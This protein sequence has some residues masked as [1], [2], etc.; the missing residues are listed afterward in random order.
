MEPLSTIGTAL[1]LLSSLSSQTFQPS[2]PASS[3]VSVAVPRS[4]TVSMT[5]TPQPFNLA[6]Q[7][8]KHRVL[9]VFAPS[10]Q[11]PAYQQQ[12]RL[13]QGQDA[14]VHDRDLLPIEVL[15]TGTSRANGTAIATDSA[16]ALRQQF[17]I[18]PTEFAVILVGKDGT[19]KQRHSTPVEPATIF[20]TIDA[21]PMRQQEIRRKQVSPAE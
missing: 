3:P 11:S 15:A 17:G 5:Q 18:A 6:A 4:S 1:L 9:L 13:W 14:E 10:E 16:N 21:M 19:E 12:Q 7:Q 8:W 2:R 20:S